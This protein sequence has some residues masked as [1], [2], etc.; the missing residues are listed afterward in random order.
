MTTQAYC[1]NGVRISTREV[2]DAI[3]ELV[4]P[5]LA[6]LPDD[7]EYVEATLQVN[8]QGWIF[9]TGDTG[10]IQAHQGYFG[11]ATIFPDYGRALTE[12]ELEQAAINL[13]DNAL[14][15]YWDSAPNAFLTRDSLEGDDWASIYD[16]QDIEAALESVG[17]STEGITGVHVLVGEGEYTEI[18][19]TDDCA[20]YRYV[21]E[22]WR[23]Y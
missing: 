6:N 4:S 13:L 23:V 1:I 11:D 12:S 8:D 14:S 9:H 19:V 2:M 5:L 15:G 7:E 17:A 18:W 20:P 22:F 21:A 3:E 16:S 10:Y